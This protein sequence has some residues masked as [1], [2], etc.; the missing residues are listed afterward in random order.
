[1]KT[2]LSKALDLYLYSN[3]HI[4]LCAMMFCLEYVHLSNYQV[5]HPYF[6]FIGGS[7]VLLYLVHRYIGYYR[8]KDNH[9]LNERYQKIESFIPYYP[10]WGL[11]VWI[12]VLYSA[13]RLAFSDLV[14][15]IVPC[16]ISILYVL[17]VFSNKQRLRDFAYIKIFAIAITWTWFSTW[18]LID[19]I[20]IGTYIL[21][22]CEQM[23]FML[24]ITLPFDI[25]DIGIDS[26]D[27]VHTIAT[28][29][30]YEKTK[31]LSIIFISLSI[32]CFIYLVISHQISDQAI[33][34]LPYVILY[35]LIIFIIRRRDTYKQDVMITG[36]LDGSIL[37][38]GVLGLLLVG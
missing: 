2:A 13:C 37:I 25:R 23:F 32:L 16:I 17:P 7:T 1:M 14:V 12:F 33:I 19:N 20:D 6:G 18:F 15:L 31:N 3:F 36:A 10:I 38:K 26:K 11:L 30:G 34:I 9:I 22:A 4:G 29:L 8:V 24:G 27:G 28:K 35:L 21:I 5:T